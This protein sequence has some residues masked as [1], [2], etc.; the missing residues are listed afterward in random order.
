MY[1]LNKESIEGLGKFQVSQRPKNL[2]KNIRFE[3]SLS[4]IDEECEAVVRYM[5][6]NIIDKRKYQYIDV[7]YHDL[8]PT[9]SPANGLWHLDSSLNADHYY[10]NY[11]WV[12]GVHNLTEYVENVI[13]IPACK[14]SKEFD[15]LVNEEML[16]IN[17]FESETVTRFY[18]DRIHRSPLCV[19]GEPRTLIRLVNT[20]RKLPTYKFK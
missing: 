15:K 2:F 5:Y 7:K 11:L 16:T 17:R 13:T 20:D 10:E 9:Q 3:K 19:R 14:S 1:H 8:Q 18:G 4:L 12:N 6:E